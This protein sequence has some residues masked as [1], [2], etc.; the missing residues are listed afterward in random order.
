M[1]IKTKLWISITSIVCYRHLSNNFHIFEENF[2]FLK[3][4]VLFSI[5]T[6][7]L[8]FQLHF[9][10]A[11]KNRLLLIFILYYIIILRKPHTFR[12]ISKNIIS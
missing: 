6:F 8:T 1:R 4:C 3:L 9:T 10:I 7:I 12:V 11:L 5:L 2:Y